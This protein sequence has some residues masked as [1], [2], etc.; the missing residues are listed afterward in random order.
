MKT[1]QEQIKELKK[2][3][4]ELL[5]ALEGIL[6]RPS[7]WSFDH[8]LKVYDKAKAMEVSE[9][10]KPVPVITKKALVIDLDKDPRIMNG[11]DVRVVID[12]LSIMLDQKAYNLAYDTLWECW[13]RLPHEKGGHC[14]IYKQD[15]G[16]RILFSLLGTTIRAAVKDI[17]PNE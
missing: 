6:K 13:E 11:E 16:V 17:K 9:A 15:M 7:G 8:A 1:E 12:N 2:I 14:T 4:F 5:V 10:E 3:R